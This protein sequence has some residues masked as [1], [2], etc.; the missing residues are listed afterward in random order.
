VF[1]H[2]SVRYEDPEYEEH[3]RFSARPLDKCT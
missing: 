1:Y 2:F 3:F